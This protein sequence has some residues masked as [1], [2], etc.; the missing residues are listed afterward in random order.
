M[1]KCLAIL[2]ANGV[3][4]STLTD[5]LCAL[6]DGRAPASLPNETRIAGFSFMDED[7]TVLDCP[8]Q[9]AN[10]DLSWTVLDGYYLCSSQTR[11]W[12]PPTACVH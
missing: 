7:W 6:E 8:G 4:K 2:G 9:M 12:F 3:G 10:P 5:R 1:G 11:R